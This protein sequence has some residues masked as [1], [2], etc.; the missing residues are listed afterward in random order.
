MAIY[1]DMPRNYTLNVI[2]PKEV[3]TDTA[4]EEQAVAWGAV[5]NC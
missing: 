3:T 2:G 5:E 4:C 1:F